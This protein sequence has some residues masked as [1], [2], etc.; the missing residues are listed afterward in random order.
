[1]HYSCRMG[2]NRWIA[3]FAASVIAC[4][5]SSGDDPCVEGASYDAYT[6]ACYCD[7]GYS[8]DPA[9]ACEPHADVCADAETRVGHSVCVHTMDDEHEWN[10]LTLGVGPPS[11]GTRSYG[12]YLLPYDLESRLPTLFADANYY[13]LLYCLMARGFEPLFPGLA[14]DEQ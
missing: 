1:M 11:A 10:R 12:K 2:W 3:A 5:G 7:P 4:G 8:G 9:D 14:M 6:E 13:R